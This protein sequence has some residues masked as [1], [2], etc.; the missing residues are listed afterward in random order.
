[1]KTNL[2]IF[3]LDGTLLNTLEDIS[4]CLNAA[5][6]DNRY[7]EKTLDQVRSY[8]GG[9][10]EEM[11]SKAVPPDARSE[12]EI[13]RLTKEYRAYYTKHWN[14]KT[15]PFPQIPELLDTLIERGIKMAVLSNKYHDFSVRCVEGLLGDWKFEMVVGRQKKYPP[16]PDPA[17]ALA[18]A[19][20]L[21]TDTADT[22]LLGDGEADMKTAVTAGMFPA[23]ACWGFRTGSQL[24][25]AGARKLFESPLDVLEILE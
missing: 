21:N 7:P 3:D 20:Q 16:K 25:L 14:N 11:I 23:G 1:M 8:V 5:L 6:R 18:I 19:N 22:V 17:G 13:F 2:I 12:E 15:V 4:D 24:K 10:L 9:G